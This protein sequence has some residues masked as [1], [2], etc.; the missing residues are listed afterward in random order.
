MKKHIAELL[1][2]YALSLGVTPDLIKKGIWENEID[3][4]WKVKLN[5]QT[6][7]V[8]NVPGLS[9]YIEF[10]GW[11]AGIM[12]VLGEGVLCAGA[13]GNEENLRSAI[14]ERMYKTCE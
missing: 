5:G 1:L 2:E 7:K 4:H 8:E 10:N 6:E 14:E 9:W 13:A 11:P 12:N 3:K